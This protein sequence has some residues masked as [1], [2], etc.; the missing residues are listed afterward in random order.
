VND[1]DIGA[2]LSPVLNGLGILFQ[3]FH[4]ELFIGFLFE[5]EREQS[6]PLGV[7]E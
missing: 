7:D 5:P 4:D 1:V 6:N 2:F 3:S